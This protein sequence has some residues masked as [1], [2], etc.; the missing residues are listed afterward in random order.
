M[1]VDVWSPSGGWYAQPA[2]WKANTAIMAGVMTAITAV[3]W[4]ISA[5]REHR[6]R[7]PEVRLSIP[8][9]HR[10]AYSALW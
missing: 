9:A 10:N 2:N 4:K 6:D 7:M 1:R 5:E 3:V 8:R